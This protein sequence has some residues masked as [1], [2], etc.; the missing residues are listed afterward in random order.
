ME[1]VQIVYKQ[2]LYTVSHWY[3]ICIVTVSYTYWNEIFWLEI[4]QIYI[5]NS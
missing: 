1:Q 5:I 3:V 2:M 4:Y